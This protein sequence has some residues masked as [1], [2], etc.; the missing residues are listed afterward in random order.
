[1]RITAGIVARDS[2]NFQAERIWLVQQLGVESGADQ[3]RRTVMVHGLPV[4]W[5]KD[6]P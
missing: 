2:A 3:E 4:L 1:M 6:E 5:S